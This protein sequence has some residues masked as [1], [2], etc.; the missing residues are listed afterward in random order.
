[1]VS[2][3]SQY[4]KALKN[5]KLTFKK[6]K[7]IREGYHFE[8]HFDSIDNNSLEMLCL[9]PDNNQILQTLNHSCQIAHELAEFL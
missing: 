4:I 2:K 7:S 6:E 8:C 1:M 3:I 9:W 5:E